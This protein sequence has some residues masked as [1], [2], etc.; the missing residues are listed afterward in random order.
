[1]AATPLEF[2]YALIHGNMEML[3]EVGV[4]D[5]RKAY[6]RIWDTGSHLKYCHLPFETTYGGL[7]T[8]DQRVRSALL[9]TK[10]PLPAQAANT[11]QNADWYRIYTRRSMLLFLRMVGEGKV[12]VAH[13]GPN[14]PLH[15]STIERGAIRRRQEVR[16]D[17]AALPPVKLAKM[18]RQVENSMLGYFTTLSVERVEKTEL[19][20]GYLLIVGL[21]VLLY[22]LQV[23]V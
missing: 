23:R 2:R 9:N 12:T 19:H 6:L 8:Y 5:N 17:V 14:G 4:A 22:F 16:G 1:M 13:P 18:R 21:V 10:D 20:A 11:P 3:V 7:V 15:L